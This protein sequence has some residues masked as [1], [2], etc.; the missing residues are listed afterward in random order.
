MCFWGS[1][2]NAFVPKI[3][4]VANAKGE[5]PPLALKA[6]SQLIIAQQRKGIET[7]DKFDFGTAS[8]YLT[9]KMAKDTRIFVEQDGDKY[10]IQIQ[11]LSEP[12]NFQSFKVS[13]ADVQG[14]LGDKYVN[15][16]VQESARFTIGGG[17]SDILHKNIATKALMQKRFGDFPGIK[18]LQVTANLEEDGEGSGLF[19]P[20]IYLKQKDGKYVRFEI[21]GDDKLSRVGYEQGRDNL[22]RLNDQVLL[23]T[24][25]QAYP[26]Y[27][28][29]KIDY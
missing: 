12:D 9:D 5:V 13:A 16:N 25:K 8:S 27:D 14:Y 2:A 19:I 24:L 11:N 7:D 3:K 23:T 26:T 28:F 15:K 6:V 22:N 1:S 29:S 20:T 21:S 18:K 10:K 4:A 17:K